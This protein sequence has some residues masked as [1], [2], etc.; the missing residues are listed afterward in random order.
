MR[1]L[2]GGLLAGAMMM[3]PAF[4]QHAGVVVLAQQQKTL[5]EGDVALLNHAVKADK[6][7]DYEAFLAKLKEALTKSATPEAKQQ[8]AGW[9]V[10]K[11]PK[12]L[13]DGSVHYIHVITPVP[14]A[15]Y[16]FLQLM[17]GVFTD[18]ND[19]KTLYEQYRG[20][21]ANNLGLQT[22]ALVVDMSK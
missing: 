8:L 4:S 15:D 14:G 13:A 20:A 22:G 1:R 16:N 18:P 12:P 21:L 3:L 2:F 9:K 11:T 5:F 19:Q 7:G 10:V 6:V 17:Y